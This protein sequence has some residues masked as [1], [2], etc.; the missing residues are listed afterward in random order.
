MNKVRRLKIS[1]LGNKLQDISSDLDII[2]DEETDYF[3]NMPENLQNSMRASDSEEAIDT[4]EQ[5][6]DLLEEAITLLAQI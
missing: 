1:V 6:K 2:I 5:A 3:N 4:L